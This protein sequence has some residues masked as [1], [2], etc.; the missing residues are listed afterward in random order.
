MKTI[1]KAI[2]PI[3]LAI[4]LFVA[5]PSLILFFGS[6]VLQYDLYQKILAP[7]FGKPKTV[8]IG[9]SITAGGGIWGLKIGEYNFNVW[10]YGHA[11]FTTRQIHHYAK[12]AAENK[13]TQV[14]F[15]MAG[16]NDPDKSIRGAEKTFKDYKQILNTL[17]QSNIT[18]VIQLTLYRENESAP[19][20]IDALNDLL[21]AYAK[22]TNIQVID[23]NP[24]LAP[25]QSLLPQ[26]SA[27]GVHLTKA[28]YEVWS[29]EIKKL[30]PTL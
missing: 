22:E 21:I 17:V 4:N 14:V 16:I 11:G 7:R 12:K 13:A 19:E 9:D 29:L 25:G 1:K 15:V 24:I 5:L 26:Y 20:F 28:A 6:T 3:S 18:P 8:F 23:L 30:W 2:L 10:N 27:D